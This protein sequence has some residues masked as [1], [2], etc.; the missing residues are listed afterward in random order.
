MQP[1]AHFP[2][3]LQL[4][5]QVCYYADNLQKKSISYCKSQVNVR[6]TMCVA[7]VLELSKFAK[8]REKTNTRI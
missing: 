6:T 4:P 3:S 8:M 5:Q 2:Q 1:A 7:Y